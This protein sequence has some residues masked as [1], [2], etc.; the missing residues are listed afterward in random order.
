M[1]AP[2]RGDQIGLL[3]DAGEEGWELVAVL[4]NN[5]AYLKREIEAGATEMTSNARPKIRS[6]CV[7]RSRA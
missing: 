3:C 6:Q 4:R 7:R 1:K 2:R 5:I